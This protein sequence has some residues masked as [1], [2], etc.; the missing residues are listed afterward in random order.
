MGV[1]R[2]GEYG[3]RQRAVWRASWL[4]ARVLAVPVW[5]Y[6]VKR[7]ATIPSGP[8]VI[9]ANHLSHLDVPF[10]GL[11]ARRPTRFLAVDELWGVTPVMDSVFATFG[12][13]PLP[14]GRYPLSAMRMALE[15]LDAG[16]AIGV[17]P[18]GR[19]VGA[20]GHERPRRGA[21]WLALR[22][23]AQVVP[24]AIWGTHNSMPLDEMKIRPAKVTVRTGTPMDP[25]DFLDHGDPIGAITDAWEHWVDR[26]VAELS[27]GEGYSEAAPDSGL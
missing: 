4:P 3:F 22:T 19:R 23:G 13:I 18:E 17:F 21:A 24:V 26:Q 12:A 15:H 20:W 14:R 1:P 5:R 2:I 27:S 11:A 16:G 25:D 10:V 8:V 7:E 9:A 6:Q